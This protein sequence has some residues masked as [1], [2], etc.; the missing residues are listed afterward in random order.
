MPQFICNACLKP[1]L[2]MSFLH[3][4]QKITQ[5]VIA[6]PKQADIQISK[7]YGGS[8]KNLGFN[9]NDLSSMKQLEE[10]LQ[11]SQVHIC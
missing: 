6:E 5:T 8:K 2:L 10:K 7:Y 9:L 1:L 11:V 4:L 3:A